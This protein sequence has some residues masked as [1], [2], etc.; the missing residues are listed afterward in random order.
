MVLGFIIIPVAASVIILIT[1]L[2]LGENWTTVARIP[3]LAT[4]GYAG[5]VVFKKISRETGVRL[6]IVVIEIFLAASLIVAG[7]FMTFLGL[8][9]GD[10]FMLIGGAA[11]AILSATV[12]LFAARKWDHQKRV[13]QVDE[14]RE[15]P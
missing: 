13:T 14:L 15:R 5:F 12:A 11:L 6:W 10:Y 2:A 3:L 7:I 9:L 8:F 1:G 4:F